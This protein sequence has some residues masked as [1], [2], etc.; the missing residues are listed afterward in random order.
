[1]VPKDEL[2]LGQILPGDCVTAMRSIPD[3]SV[4]M[5]FADPPYNLQLG[6]DLDRVEQARYQLDVKQISIFCLDQISGI[7]LVCSRSQSYLDPISDE[8]SLRDASCD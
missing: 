5:V 2:P 6:G 8:M 4:D 7:A 3:A 1:M